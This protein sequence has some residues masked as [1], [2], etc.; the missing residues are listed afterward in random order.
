MSW[1]RTPDTNAPRFSDADDAGDAPQAQWEQI[2]DAIG[3][4]FVTASAVTPTEVSWLW[5]PY[6]PLGHPAILAGD[7]GVGKSMVALAL[8]AAGSRGAPCRATRRVSPGPRSGS[9]SKTIC[10]PW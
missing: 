2:D 4:C 1:H 6:L 7:P 9:G 5:E 10:R 8:A 3:R